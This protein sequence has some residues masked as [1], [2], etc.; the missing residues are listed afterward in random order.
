[1]YATASILQAACSKKCNSLPT[2]V[3]TTFQLRESDCCA[4][5]SIAKKHDSCV[6]NTKEHVSSELQKFRDENMSAILAVKKLVTS[7]QESRQSDLAIIERAL[8]AVHT[9]HEEVR[10]LLW[11]NTVVSA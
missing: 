11:P 3:Y 8:A 10:I 9:N 7:A 2:V 1:M 4:S 6:Q 5:V